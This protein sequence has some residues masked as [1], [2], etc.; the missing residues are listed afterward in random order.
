MERK[1]A[2]KVAGKKNL[3]CRTERIQT[4]MVGKNLKEQSVT[5]DREL[6]F[7]FQISDLGFS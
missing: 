1:W 4:R 2:Y 5:V 3:L 7:G 6:E